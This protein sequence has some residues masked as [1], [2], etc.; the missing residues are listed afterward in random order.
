MREVPIVLPGAKDRRG[1][2]V[3]GDLGRTVEPITVDAEWP[4]AIVAGIARPL[5]LEH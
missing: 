2:I 1:W 5:V 3:T 4:S